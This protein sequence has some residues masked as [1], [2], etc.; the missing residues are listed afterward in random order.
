MRDSFDEK[1]KIEAEK[2]QALKERGKVI[3]DLGKAQEADLELVHEGRMH[4][5]LA[6]YKS[7]LIE[8][9]DEVTKVC[10]ASYLQ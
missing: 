8:K 10:I 7:Q 9:S 3:N 4:D 6:N 5:V 1:M 2:Y